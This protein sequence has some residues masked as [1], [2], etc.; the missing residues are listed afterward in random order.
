MNQSRFIAVLECCESMCVKFQK[1]YMRV[2]HCRHDW[3]RWQTDKCVTKNVNKA[4]IGEKGLIYSRLCKFEFFSFNN[5]LELRIFNKI[6]FHP[7]T[8]EKWP[9]QCYELFLSVYVIWGLNETINDWAKHASS[10]CNSRS[11]EVLF[12]R[13][14]GINIFKILTEILY[15]LSQNPKMAKIFKRNY[16]ISSF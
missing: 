13:K 12:W 1:F 2:N 14:F 3:V 8:K 11:N 7:K 16:F 6:R 15:F 4:A 5:S 10:E 9:Y